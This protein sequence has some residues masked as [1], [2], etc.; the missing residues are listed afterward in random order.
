MDAKS[1]LFHPICVHA[2][3]RP[4]KQPASPKRTPPPPPSQP[5]TEHIVSRVKASLRSPIQ[6]LRHA[7]HLA[8]RKK[9]RLSAFHQIGGGCAQRWRA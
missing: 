2:Q 5:L 4:M 8:Q 9:M 7:Q 3:C 1:C 6:L